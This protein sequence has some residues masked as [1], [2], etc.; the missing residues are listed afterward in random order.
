MTDQR[1]TGIV[2][3]HVPIN[4]LATV[5]SRRREEHVVVSVT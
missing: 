4:R 5:G 1:L 2:A 3:S